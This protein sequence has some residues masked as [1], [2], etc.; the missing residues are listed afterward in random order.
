ME[1]RRKEIRLNSKQQLLN[2]CSG[3]AVDRIIKAAKETRA[4]IIQGR[5]E[6]LFC[7]NYGLEPK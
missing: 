7:A 5:R 3:L 6:S 1:E 2:R 4:E